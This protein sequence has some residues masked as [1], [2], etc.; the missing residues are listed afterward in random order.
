MTS[1]NPFVPSKKFSFPED[2][3]LHKS[4]YD[5]VVKEEELACGS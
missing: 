1:K 2:L 4:F 3:S 5:E